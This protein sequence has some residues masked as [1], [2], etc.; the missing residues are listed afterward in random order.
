[1]RKLEFWRA[2]HQELSGGRP[3]FLALVA[4]HTRHSPGTRGAALMLTK[5]G[6]QV[7]TIG[8]GIM[9]KELLEQARAA[10]SG[11]ASFVPRAR[12]LYHRRD[13]PG[14]R[15]GLICAGRQT[16]VAFVARPDRDLEA[17]DEA[18]SRLEADRAGLLCFAPDRGLWLEEQGPSVEL[19]PVRLIRGDDWRYEEQLLAL[20]RV[21]IF[22]GGHCGLAL[23]RQMSW[24][25]YV[26]TIADTRPEVSTLAENQWA[27]HRIVRPDYAE[28]AGLVDHPEVSCAVV[29][30]ADFPSDVRALVGALRQ[31]FPYLGLMGA[32]AKLRAID[33]AL[34]AEGFGEEALARL[35][36][37]VGLPIGSSTP[38]EI[39]VSVAAQ[40]ISLRPELFPARGPAPRIVPEGEEEER[41]PGEE[42]LS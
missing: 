10:L 14:A 33:Q 37:P 41:Q 6:Q 8:G 27:R 32:P 9:E 42:G 31:P 20:D 13:A 26:V 4:D 15:S 5:A 7:G 1:M 21:V 38:E 2:V 3:A 40:L 11:D 23:S 12:D 22:G 25:G 19:P 16:N 35:V 24:L 28:V 34:R 39:A 18:V 29:M 30:T 17:V 36:A